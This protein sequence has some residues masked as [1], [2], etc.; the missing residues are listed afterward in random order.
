M[1]FTVFE[2]GSR[3]G[4]AVERGSEWVGMFSDETAYPGDIDH[5][6]QAGADFSEVATLLEKGHA[7]DL[8]AV[9]V[10]PPVSR[11]RKIICVG[12]NYRDHSAET[13]FQEPD[14]PT[15]FARF[16]S[17]LTG[18]Y[19]PISVP[20]ESLQ[21]DFEGELVAVI[22]KPGHRIPVGSAL[23]HVAGYSIFNDATL[24]D[25]QFRTPQ[26]TI[27]KNFD[28]TGALGPYFV[29]AASLPPGCKGLRLQTRLNGATVQDADV[30]D[31]VFDVAT[32]V[33]TLSTTLTLEA[34]DL[35][36]TGT[37]AGV[38]MARTPPL[39]M[40]AGDVCE[41]EIDRLG[42]LRNPISAG[43]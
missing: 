18:P 10:L 24:R 29:T 38:G 13:G 33:S 39:W 1:R 14:Y 28:A 42:V 26:W 15:V 25:F 7:I 5:L 2:S 27:G 16:A 41:V 23:A 22:G 31:M 3:R 35:I 37:P 12:L 4:L 30:S 36:V 43:A 21:L 32:L 6:L 34:G 8:E 40:K 20:P 19:D 9:R 11:P 17:S